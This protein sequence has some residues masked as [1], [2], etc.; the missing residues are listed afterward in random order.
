[1]KEVSITLLMAG[2]LM[3]GRGYDTGRQGGGKARCLGG[4]GGS[5]E[6]KDEPA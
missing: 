6:D 1:M 2:W 3:N 5:D 4:G